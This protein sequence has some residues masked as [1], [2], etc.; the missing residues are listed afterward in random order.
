MNELEIIKRIKDGDTEAFSVLVEKYHRQL[1]RFIFRLVGDE[2]IVEDIG[3]EV[4]LSVYKS[5]KDFDGQRGTPFSA[6]LFIA[7]RN[8]CISE[9]RSRRGAE[10]VRI[11]DM[12]SLRAEGKTAEERIIE[13]ERMTALRGSLDQLAEP[14]KSTI[15]RSLQGDSMDDIAMEDGISIGTVKSRLFRAR[16]K[17]KLLVGNYF[18]GKDY[19]GI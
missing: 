15:L 16:E 19:E 7:A 14:Y 2:Q 10:R 11:E 4:F 17:V 1:L 18:G 5:L 9:L 3:Q 13:N 8:R 12:D 6:W